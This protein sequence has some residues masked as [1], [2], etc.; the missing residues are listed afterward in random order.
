MQKLGKEPSRRKKLQVRKELTTSDQ[1]LR[2]TVFLGCD[3]SG[4]N[5]RWGVAGGRR[6]GGEE[7]ETGR[8]LGHRPH[9][10]SE[11][12]VRTCTLTVGE[13]GNQWRV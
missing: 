13:M 2:D 5:G 9:T 11:G 10:S 4:G 7:E 8:V 6:G 3:C 12:T 1:S